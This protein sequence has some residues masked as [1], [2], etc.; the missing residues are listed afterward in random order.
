MVSY[1][2]IFQA[3]NPGQ[4]NDV[5]ENYKLTPLSLQLSEQQRQFSVRFNSDIVNFIYER[6][7]N[8]FLVKTR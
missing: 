8:L 3:R 4:I 6:F 2:G 7:L 5:A 1:M